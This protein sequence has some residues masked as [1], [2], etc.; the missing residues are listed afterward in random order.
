MIPLGCKIRQPAG[1]IVSAF[2]NLLIVQYHF[3]AMSA[4]LVG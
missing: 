1:E 2:E 4:A 3:G